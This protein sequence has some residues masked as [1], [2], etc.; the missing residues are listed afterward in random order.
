MIMT[1]VIAYNGFENWYGVNK[2]ICKCCVEFLIFLYWISFCAFG[3]IEIMLVSCGLYQILSLSE[4]QHV[5]GRFFLFSLSFLF[6]LP[7]GT[8]FT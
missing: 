5:V 6:I 1:V 2:F 3:N 4:I 8:D 7:N